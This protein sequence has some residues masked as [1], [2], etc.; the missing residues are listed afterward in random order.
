MAVI[1]FP[2]NYCKSAEMSGAVFSGGIYY[3]TMNLEG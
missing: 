1:V 3:N 2:D